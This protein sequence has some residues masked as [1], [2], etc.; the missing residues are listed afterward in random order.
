MCPVMVYVQVQHFTTDRHVTNAALH[1]IYKIKIFI[2][3]FIQT[4]PVSKKY[5][6]KLIGKHK[7]KVSKDR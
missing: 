4:E 1:S 3:A 5:I 7:V 2:H 6:F